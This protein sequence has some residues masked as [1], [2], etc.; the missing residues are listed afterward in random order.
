MSQQH[1]SSRS[2]DLLVQPAE[3]AGL[4][5]LRSFS[6]TTW[7]GKPPALSAQAAAAK[8]WTNTGPD[9]LSC[10]SCGSQI[11][12]KLPLNPWSEAAAGIVTKYSQR[13]V[14]AHSPQCRQRSLLGLGD[15]SDPPPA[16]APPPSRSSSTSVAFPIIPTKKLSTAYYARLQELQQLQSL[17]AVSASTRARLAAAAA[18]LD[19]TILTGL[20]ALLHTPLDTLKH[21][22]AAA[23]GAPGSTSSSTPAAAPTTNLSR[24]QAQVLTALCG[25]QPRQLLPPHL[26]PAAAAD[27]GGALFGVSHLLPSRRSSQAGQHSTP[28]A[29]QPQPAAAAA[30]A[31]GSSVSPACTALECELCGTRVGLWRFSCSGPFFAQQLSSKA[32]RALT[33]AAAAA[34]PSSTQPPSEAAAAGERSRNGTPAQAAA[35][36]QNPTSPSPTAGDAGSRE[37]QLTRAPSGSAAAAGSL[38]PTAQQA[39]QQ[40]QQHQAGEVVASA[41]PEAVFSTLTHTIAGGSLLTAGASG[42][43]GRGPGQ[44]RGVKFAFGRA[45]RVRGGEQ[46]Q[47]CSMLPDSTVSRQL[48]GSKVALQ[49]TV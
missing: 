17:P 5:R 43:R 42:E 8:G 15:Q 30:A 21:E 7:F 18:R 28:P 45:K 11:L 20:A 40:Q 23:V 26:A 25:W 3:N 10:L 4:A 29:G 1:K 9:Q 34:A 13:L 46:Q 2:S 14:D 35:T 32:M 16:A 38:S 24:E 41:S 27:A 33:T 44:Q 22:A 6:A 19:P 48:S 39:Q 36:D 49:S 37:Q 31:A 47:C 12:C